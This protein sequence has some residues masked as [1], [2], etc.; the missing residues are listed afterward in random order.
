MGTVRKPAERATYVA[1][2]SDKEWLCNEQ[3]KLYE[4]SWKNPDYVF[5]KLWG[6][7]TDPRNLRIGVERV[8]HNVGRRSAGVDGATAA[9]VLRQ[10]IDSFVDGLRAELRAG[11]Y[12]PMPVRRV[13]IPKPGR[14]GK[15][16]PLGIPTVKDRVVQ[17]AMKNILEP[18]FEADFFPT[19][20]GFRP[21]R[22]AHGAIE[23][24][25]ILMHP[26]ATAIRAGNGASYQWA[27]EAD[28]KGCFD[29]IDHHKL[30]IRIR[31]RVGDA[32][33]NRLI[34]AFL[35]AGVLADGLFLRGEAGTP[36]G[37]ILSPLLA[38]IALSAI[39]ERYERHVWPR[40][41]P[42]LLTDPAKVDARGRK[43]RVT[44]RRNGRTV[45]VPIRYADDFVILV[46][47]PP[48]DD[49]ESK[50]LE[51]ALNEKAAL[52]AFLKETLGLE[53][54]EEKTLVTPV[55]DGVTFL[56]HHIGVRP[57][58]ESGRPVC[59]VVIPKDRSQRLREHIKDL[60]RRNTTKRTLAQRLDTL[61]PMLRGWANFYRHANRSNRVFNGIDHYVWFTI[62][63]WLR[64]KH[65]GA[66]AAEIIARY[67]R[68]PGERAI[69]W[70]EGEQKCFTMTSSRTG[71]KWLRT[72][73]GPNYARRIHGEPSA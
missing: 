15:F 71:R 73:R 55:T 51:A 3:T 24:L 37:G 60:F 8:T 5:C 10:G 25:R 27:I 33:V 47:A 54:S 52:A 13:N 19:S 48:G 7:I 63:R 50:S 2:Q 30:M 67:G 31:R 42:T 29:N 57:H 59:S 26:T 38:N 61:N 49:R 66:T 22:S 41:T 65:Q 53:L 45:F 23:H 11:T 18:I 28:I 1:N 39:D 62:Y 17:A 44:D 35:K 64:K 70:K 34:V 40:R 69:Q 14:P 32:K 46:G 6:L 58:F 56:G 16:R 4:C 43:Y 72:E 9:M 21:G 68:R 12:R 36:Q 20:Y